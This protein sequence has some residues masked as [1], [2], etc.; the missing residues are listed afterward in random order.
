M[1]DTLTV[2]AV[3]GKVYGD[4][5]RKG[6]F[7]GLRRKTKRDPAEAVV[8]RVPGGL[9][10]VDAGPVVVSN[11]REI[12]RAILEGGLRLDD[13]SAK[14]EPAKPETK[15]ATKSGGGGKD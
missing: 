9:D 10:Y 2:R 12:R 3:P 1:A 7:I 11:T 6:E 13:G 8:Y 5:N 15:K 14:D 4:P